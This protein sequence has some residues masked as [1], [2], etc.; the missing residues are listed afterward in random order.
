[1]L[2]VVRLVAR[3]Y[4]S[5][6]APRASFVVICSRI[7]VQSAT[8][9]ASEVLFEMHGRELRK[10]ILD[11]QRSVFVFVCLWKTNKNRTDSRLGEVVDIHVYAAEIRFAV[12]MDRSRAIFKYRPVKEGDEAG[13][14]SV[15]LIRR[16][17]PALIQGFSLRILGPYC[18]I[19]ALAPEKVQVR[20]SEEVC[21]PFF[22]AN[23]PLLFFW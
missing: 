8:G 2:T 12:E 9:A 21:A 4:R 23:S 5:A 7:D 18:K 10:V 11:S 6:L 17:L 22:F 20:M 16:G 15:R 3:S 1:M 19:L 14:D 13:P